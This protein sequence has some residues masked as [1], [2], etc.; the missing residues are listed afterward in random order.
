[1]IMAK[2]V[3][4]YTITNCPFCKQEKE[5]LTAHNI[6]FE[7]KNVEEHREYLSEM[8]ELSDKFA[9]VP[10]TM[11]TKE[12]GSMAK[13]K[14]FTQAEFDEALGISNM[15]AVSPADSKPAVLADTPAPIVPP[16]QPVNPDPEP[17][18]PPLPEPTPTPMP[19]PEPS[20]VPT[21]PLPTADPVSQT[22]TSSAEDILRAI[23]STPPENMSAPVN[24]VGVSP[25]AAN[26]HQPIV[27]APPTPDPLKGVLNNLENMSTTVPGQVSTN[28]NL[29]NIPDFSAK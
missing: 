28:S 21:P 6:A 13:L 23:N 29:P 16:S 10:F 9:G 4:I 11:I 7:E 22:K 19:M 17:A 2:K 27:E 25:T 8:L 5:Y 3:T 14:G 18:T 1:M 12:D 26:F 15:A 20:P 24:E